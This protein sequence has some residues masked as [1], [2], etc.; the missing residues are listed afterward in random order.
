METSAS[1]LATSADFTAQLRL[2]ISLG[3]ARWN[4]TRRGASQKV[5][6]PSPTASRTS[7]STSFSAVELLGSEQIEGRGFHPQ[8]RLVNFLTLGGCTNAIHM[9]GKKDD[10]ERMLDLVYLA[11]QRINGLPQ[12]LRCGAKT[13]AAQDFQ[14]NSDSFPVRNASGLNQKRMFA[15]R[16]TLF[17]QRLQTRVADQEMM[18]PLRVN[19]V[20]RLDLLEARN[21]T[22]TSWF[23]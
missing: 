15:L 6:N 5:P 17:L 12:L 22:R 18:L 19:L 8:R 20:S 10:A 9:P 1:S 7:P 2:I 16:N 11:A 13:S 21:M 14:E 4:S 23:A 3:L